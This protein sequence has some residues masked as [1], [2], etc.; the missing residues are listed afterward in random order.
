MD[1]WRP[2]EPFATIRDL[3]SQPSHSRSSVSLY[4][5][6]RRVS[7]DMKTAKSAKS[8][9][10]GLMDPSCD[11]TITVCYQH[12]VFS[13]NKTR[14][15]V[16]GNVLRISCL[17][18]RGAAGYECDETSATQIP[19]FEFDYEN[20]SPATF[21]E[22]FFKN[23]DKELVRQLEQWLAERILASGF[24]RLPAVS[25]RDKC[26]IDF[27]CQ[28]LE[29]R[30]T[31]KNVTLTVWDGELPSVP[32]VDSFN[33]Q[34]SCNI[35]G[36]SYR[37]R[38]EDTFSLAPHKHVF[39]TVWQNE[40]QSSV[41][42]FL[43]CSS[44]DVNQTQAFL[45]FLNT[46]VSALDGGVC[47]HMRSGHH[48]GKAVRVIHPH[49]ILGRLLHARLAD[50][51]FDAE[52]ENTCPSVEETASATE[53]RSLT[54]TEQELIRSL[55]PYMSLDLL[56]QWSSQSL[57]SYETLVRESQE[58]DF[59]EDEQTVPFGREQLLRLLTLVKS[60]QRNEVL[61]PVELPASQ[62]LSGM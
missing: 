38:N 43:T 39:V 8:K 17:R 24:S 42:H 44:L 40:S 26:Y 57:S 50:A 49:S 46:E 59:P 47:L 2:P 55:P 22:E 51:V 48:Q 62:G 28:V 11:S 54:S 45:L 23:G 4:G 33:V 58:E 19:T 15:I 1:S 36:D 16:P 18:P 37:R 25:G 14:V 53:T 9:T 31:K 32:V 30:A 29:Q 35:Y 13:S 21:A 20:G 34:Y 10:L 7:A 60:I 5:V 52:L 41:D 27:A 61:L 3:L 12:N 6:V 56:I